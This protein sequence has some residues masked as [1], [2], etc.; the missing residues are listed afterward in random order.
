[1]DT[2]T[3]TFTGN[4]KRGGGLSTV[5]FISRGSTQC[6]ALRLVCPKIEKELFGARMTELP[7]KK[8]PSEPVKKRPIRYYKLR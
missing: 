5:K 2:W 4:P 8:N 3:F 7:V 1:M 6:Q